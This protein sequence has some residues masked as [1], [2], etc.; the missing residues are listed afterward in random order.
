[1]ASDEGDPPKNTTT[2]VDVKISNSTTPKIWPRD[3]NNPNLVINDNTRT[4]ALIS[5]VSFGTVLTTAK[6]IVRCQSSSQADLFRI[7]LTT[8]DKGFNLFAAGDFDNEKDT[9][10]VEVRV[11]TVGLQD[12]NTCT[13]VLVQSTPLIL[14]SLT[15]NYLLY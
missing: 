12:T 5:H 9:K 7:E 2:S 11:Y 8:D 4:D 10:V 13:M 3:K 1:M 15:L 6:L 14:R